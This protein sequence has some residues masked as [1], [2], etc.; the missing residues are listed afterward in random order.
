MAVEPGKTFTYGLR[1]EAMPRRFR[2]EFDLSKPA[3]PPP[4]P[5]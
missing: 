4:P 5:W 2:V 3:P 1:R